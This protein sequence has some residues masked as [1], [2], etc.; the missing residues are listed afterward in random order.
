M[1]TLKDICVDSIL[2][3][4]EL[5][6]RDELLFGLNP[7]L[8][9]A[10]ASGNYDE[11]E[12][13]QFN[14]CRQTAVFTAKFL[15]DFLPN[16]TVR[17]YEG[18]FHD[19]ICQ[20]PVEYIHYFGTI[21]TESRYI[22][23]D[24][25]R[26]TRKLL[27]YPIVDEERLYPFDYGYEQMEIEWLKEINWEEMFYDTGGE[28]FTGMQPVDL[29]DYLLDCKSSLDKNKKRRME[30]ANDIYRKFTYIIGGDWI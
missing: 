8:K 28:Y 5:L 19:F 29:Y 25:S 9:L 16:Y 1:V 17:V 23:V 2:S 11:F 4:N 7:V 13:F 12:R 22:L 24:M 18:K 21:E 20:H 3:K 30:F 27:F 6:A 10:L 15:Y 14:S 26:T